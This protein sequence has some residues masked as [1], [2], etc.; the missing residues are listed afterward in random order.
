MYPKPIQKLIDLFKNFPTVGK[1]TATRFSFYLLNASDEEI[2]DLIDGLRQIKSTV[3]NC[4]FCQK[5]LEKD[6]ELCSICNDD[7]RNSQL[8]IVERET[9][10]MSLEETNQYNGYYFILGG[11]ISPLRKQDLENIRLDKLKERIE[12]SENFDM[13]E[14]EEVIIATNPTT[15]GESTG[16]FLERA[17]EDLNVKITKLA[18]GL[19][20]GGELEYADEDTLSSALKGRK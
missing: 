8:A 13:K 10:L 20:V 12:N 3:H 16:L 15:E 7:S 11:N 17:L 2:E 14:I 5:S 6:K 9:D 1:R 4:K 18:K 19:P